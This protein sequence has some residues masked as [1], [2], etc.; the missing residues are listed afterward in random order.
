METLWVNL[1]AGEKATLG[2]CYPLQSFE[3]MADTNWDGRERDG[4]NRWMDDKGVYRRERH[5]NIEEGN[6]FPE[7]KGE[8]VEGKKG[9]QIWA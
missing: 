7:G 8:K 6:L 1:N 3:M 9:W 2:S 4:G 5:F